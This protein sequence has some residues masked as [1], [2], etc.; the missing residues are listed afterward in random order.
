MTKAT[1][2]ISRNGCAPD[3]CSTTPGTLRK[4]LGRRRAQRRQDKNIPL[5]RL[6]DKLNDRFGTDFK[7][8]DQLF[9]D[10]VAERAAED[11]TLNTAAGANTLDN[12]EHVFDRMLEGFFVDSM[13]GNE[14]IFDRIMNDQGFRHLASEQLMREV[15]ERLGN[16]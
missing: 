11:E 2:R 7:Q 9:L 12:F 3:A 5:S 15:Y 14:A 1:V 16:C 13:E 4:N 10:Q 6:V 8:A